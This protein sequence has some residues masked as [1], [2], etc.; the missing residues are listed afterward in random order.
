MEIQRKE[1]ELAPR[2]GFNGDGL[3]NDGP[4]TSSRYSSGGGVSYVGEKDKRGRGVQGEVEGIEDDDMEIDLEKQAKSQ[5]EED[6]KKE[7]DTTPSDW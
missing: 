6:E 3:D 5:E 7:N 2:A 1:N 4:S